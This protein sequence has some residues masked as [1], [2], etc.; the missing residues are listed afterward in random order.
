[1]FTVFSIILTFKPYP[2]FID[3]DQG[4]CRVG[5]RCRRI[6]LPRTLAQSS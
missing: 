2:I 3:T 6:M 1:M 4:M 5:A